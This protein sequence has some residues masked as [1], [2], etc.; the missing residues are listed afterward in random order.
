MAILIDENSFKGA[1]NAAN[2]NTLPDLCRQ[3][4]F[5]DVVRSLP[6][7]LR[8]KAPAANNN[9]PANVHSVIL[10]DDAKASFLFG[11][12]ARAGTGTKGSL[13]VQANGATPTAGQVSIGPEGDIYFA[14]ADVWTD[15]DIF[16]APTKVDVLEA[17]FNVATQTVTLPTTRK[18]V[19][20]MAA[21]A[22]TPAA[23]GKTVLVP[24]DTPGANG[25]A[26]LNLAKTQ[27]LLNASDVSTSLLVKYG[28]VPTI[29]L[30]ALLT[31][32]SF[33]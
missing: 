22:V 10:A 28:V 29:D 19:N 15:V 8:G 14:A 7:H 33:V 24:S 23:L 27:V 1:L 30:D 31:A 16:Y 4:M 18:V 9:L 5:G 11:A 17:T 21:S 13:S 3:M 25:T 26:R 2:P 20:V 32:R 6:T 12:Y